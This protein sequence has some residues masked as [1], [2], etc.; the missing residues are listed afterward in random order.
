MKYL[1]R[2]LCLFGVHDWEVEDGQDLLQSS[3]I[4]WFKCKRC[5]NRENTL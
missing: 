1:R 4:P 5:G 2:L 3:G